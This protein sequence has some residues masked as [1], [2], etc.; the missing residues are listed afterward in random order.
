[1]VEALHR[2]A[3]VSKELE[4]R[5]PDRAGRQREAAA[6][7]SGVEE[8]VAQFQQRRRPFREFTG[9]QGGGLVGKS[10]AVFRLGGNGGEAGRNRQ[11]C[12]EDF[13]PCPA[14]ALIVSG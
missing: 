9:T 4:G 1:I 11:Y 5:V 7:V 3:K 10:A 6:N 14:H 13:L 2:S 12:R 8:S